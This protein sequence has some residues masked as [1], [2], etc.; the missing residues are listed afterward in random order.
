M[1]RGGLILLLLLAGVVL[2]VVGSR[3][4]ANQDEPRTTS[5]TQAE[6]PR[7]SQG[8]PREVFETIALI[9][10]GGPYPY[11]R[12]GVVF[13]NREGL[14][15]QHERGYWREY[16][17]PTPGESDRGARRI[18]AGRSGELYYTADHYRSFVRVKETR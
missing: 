2:I 4:I 17:V 14:L 1:R 6:T 16:T 8:L 11:S 13:M 7:S 9:E 12:D 5:T 15:P 10:S 18:V 3:D